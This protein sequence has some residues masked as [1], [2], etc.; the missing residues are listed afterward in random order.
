MVFALKI[1]QTTETDKKYVAFLD[2]NKYQLLAIENLGDHIEFADV[3]SQLGRTER[4][5]GVVGQKS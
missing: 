3:L 4:G 2:G 1:P 5:Q